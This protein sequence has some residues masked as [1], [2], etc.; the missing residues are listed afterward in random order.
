MSTV[1]GVYKDMAEAQKAVGALKEANYS[2]EQIS[3]VAANPDDK[4]GTYVNGHTDYR[5][6]DVSGSEGAVVGGIEGGLIGLTLGL[7]ALLIPGVGP[8]VAM[9]PLLAGLIGAGVG[10]VT[11][12]VTASLIDLGVSEDRAHLYGKAMH[13]G[14][15]LVAVSGLNHDQID[16]VEDIMNVFDVVDIDERS[17]YWTTQGWTGQAPDESTT[18]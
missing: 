10:A 9:G 4:Y 14:Y 17:E 1:V 11:G 15:T 6:D 7:G 8:I 18:R 13:E 12:G 5:D 2:D 16:N 3:L